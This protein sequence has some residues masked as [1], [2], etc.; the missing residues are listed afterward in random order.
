LKLKHDETLS[1][2]IRGKVSIIQKKEGYRFNID[3]VIL[4]SFPKITRKKGK[5]IDLGTGSGIILIL[6]SLRYPELDFH[7]V[8]IQEDLFDIAYRN[9]KINA[10][11]VNLHK[12]D[13]KDIKKFYSPQSFDYVITNPPYFKEYLSKKESLEERLAKYEISATVEDFIK[14]GSYLLRDKGRFYMIYPS[15][16]FSYITKVMIEN[17]IQP[18]RYRFVHPSLNDRA[19]HFLIEGMK[20]GKKG[21][22]IIEKPMII[23]DN[24]NIKKYSDELE[25]LLEKFV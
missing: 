3:S 11:N 20:S 19:S 13:I 12:G 2:F 22:E 4:A 10:V 23:Y 18:K 7:A 14:T 1:P 8:E 9:F 21:G 24:P 6:L 15:E 17:R 5:I 16:R 25:F